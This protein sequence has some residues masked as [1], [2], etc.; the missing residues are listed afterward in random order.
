MDFKETVRDYVKTYLKKGYTKE[1][2]KVALEKSNVSYDVIEEVFNEQKKESTSGLRWGVFVVLA[3]FV[4]LIFAILFILASM[5]SCSVDS[6]CPGDY[7]CLGNS[8]VKKEGVLNCQLIEDC[9][10]GYNCYKC[11]KTMI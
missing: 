1:Q 4:I 10:R 11:L 3:F 9:D 2:I 6:D 7:V 5:E 8:C